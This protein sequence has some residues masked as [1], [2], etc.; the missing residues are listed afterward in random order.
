MTSDDF[1]AMADVNGDGVVNN[2]DIQA[3]IAILANNT[4]SG[5]GGQLTAVPE[6]TSIVLLGLGALAIAFRRRNK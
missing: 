5:G 3:M 6:P 2:L 1:L 4:A